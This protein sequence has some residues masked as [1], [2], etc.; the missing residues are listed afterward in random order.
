MPLRRVADQPTWLLSRA[1]AR[2]QAILGA[3]FGQ[4]GVRGYHYR[5]MAALEQFGP[6]SQA[7]LGRNTGIDRS[8]VV[9]ALNELAEWGWIR[10]D[11]DPADR[12]RNVVSLTAA[13]L[14]RLVQLDDVLASVQDEVTAP[15]TAAE[16]RTL[17]DLLSRLVGP[18][19]H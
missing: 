1:H 13:G 10:R 17:V 2:A 4:A 6:T 9:A 5:L 3:A 14:A 12:R 18:E 8:D 16:R 15:L 11:P 7:D 19:T